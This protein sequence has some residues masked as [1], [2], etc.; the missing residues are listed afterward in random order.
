M[1]YLNILKQIEQVLNSCGDNVSLIPTGNTTPSTEFIGKLSIEIIET[2]ILKENSCIKLGKPFPES[3][4]NTEEKI[5]I[6]RIRLSTRMID[7][8][9]KK[10]PY[11][12]DEM[13][14]MINENN[15]IFGYY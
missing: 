15:T 1:S 13:K 5:C 10:C 7:D 14:N 11:N 12:N 8:Y 3:I 4:K 2:Y 6:N 9:T